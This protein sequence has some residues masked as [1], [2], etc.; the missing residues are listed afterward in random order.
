MIR[1]GGAHLR[2]KLI[3]G[4]KQEK[5][6]FLTE[7]RGRLT[8]VQQQQERD[9]QE[10]RDLR[11]LSL[12]SLS[13]NGSAPQAIQ[14]KAA[15]PD[16]KRRHKNMAIQPV[17]ALK[18]DV[19]MSTTNEKDDPHMVPSLVPDEFIFNQLGVNGVEA[20]GS[21]CHADVP[22]MLQSKSKEMASLA[23]P[24]TR[25]NP[26][27]LKEVLELL[28]AEAK[29]RIREA[30]LSKFLEFSTDRL[31]NRW[32]CGMLMRNS[33]VDENSN[34]V[35][36]RIKEGRSLWITKEVVQHVIDMPIGSQKS[37]PDDN[38]AAAKAEY[39]KV[40][41]ADCLEGNDL[42]VEQS[43][44]MNLYTEKS[45]NKLLQRGGRRDL[46]SFELKE[47]KKSLYGKFYQA[48]KKYILDSWP[49]MHANEAKDVLTN[50]ESYLRTKH[51]IDIS[52]YGNETPKVQPQGNNFDCGFHVLLYIRGFEQSDIFDIDEEKVL[53]LRQELSRYL[54]FHTKNRKNPTLEPEPVIEE[55]DDE[56]DD[57][58]IKLISDPGAPSPN[59]A[60][61]PNPDAPRPDAAKS[62]NPDDT[63]PDADKSPNPDAP[64]TIPNPDAPILDADEISTA[65]KG[66]TEGTSDS[67]SED[68]EQDSPMDENTGGT[69]GYQS[70]DSR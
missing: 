69:A 53:M 58:A 54:L 70:A 20:G 29:I 44:R 38:L 65:T 10:N 23:G 11:N 5:H 39:Q 25:F 24:Q 12:V 1:P 19:R 7:V 41:F 42:L 35:E 45:L 33:V 63:I 62:P 56:V 4:L 49:E 22:S 68:S 34:R 13:Q 3:Y 37:F 61:S 6:T 21:G 36:V 59:A 16:D 31:G 55:T 50:I 26:E 2:P 66:S 46:S 40:V 15:N 28:P 60:K 47:W 43:A 9:R 48:T 30:D 67:S 17:K 32:M 18:P 64:A 8:E 14:Y 27:V 57:D 51:N 52:G